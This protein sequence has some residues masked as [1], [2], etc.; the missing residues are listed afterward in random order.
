MRKFET[1]YQDYRVLR[2]RLNDECIEFIKEVATAWQG[3]QFPLQTINREFDV[4]DA[5]CCI[6]YDGGNHPEYASNACSEV[7]GVFIDDKGKLALS[8]EDCGHYTIDRVDYCDL[9]TIA[10]ALDGGIVYML[11]NLIMLIGGE[12]MVENGRWTMSRE[13]WDRLVDLAEGR[14]DIF[15][16]FDEDEDEKTQLEL[17]DCYYPKGFVTL[18]KRVAQIG[19]QDVTFEWGENIAFTKEQKNDGVNNETIEKISWY[20]AARHNTF[21]ADMIQRAIFDEN[22]SLADFIKG[23]TEI[24]VSERDTDDAEFT[25]I[26]FQNV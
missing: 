22:I 1:T 18:I 20:L 3:K 4:E 10:Y 7:E 8:I 15:H 5:Y 19:E 13:T 2:K 9:D 24:V 23:T 14:D 25:P 17:A 26:Q 11:D 16:Y 6:V 21:H 12:C